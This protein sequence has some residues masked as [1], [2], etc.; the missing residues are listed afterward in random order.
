[1]TAGVAASAYAGIPVTHRGLASAVAFVTGH[2]REDSDEGIDWSGLARF[3]GTLVFYMGVRELDTIAAALIEAGRPFDQPAA[4]VEA[5]TLATQRT[6]RA[7]LAEIAQAARE[8]DVKS[9]AIA[10]VGEVAEMADMLAWLPERPLTGVRVVVTRAR[11][12]AS[13]LSRVL[14]EEGARVIEAPVIRTRAIDG[15]ALDPS[16][17]D[18]IAL[19]SPNAVAGLFA[20]LAAGGRDAR[21]LAGIRIAAIGPG[22]S[23]AAAARGVMADI[24]PA[25]STA[26]GLVEALEDVEVR[27]ALIPRALVAREVLPDALRARGAEVEIL[28]VYETLPEPLSERAVREALNADYVTFTSSSTVR[29][30]LAAAGAGF[31]AHTR[32]ISIGP[33]TTATLRE[34][35]LDPHVEAARHDVD[36]VVQAL[37]DDARTRI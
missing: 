24:A 20:R 37:L 9:P 31:S 18:L 1:V 25:T 11:D 23:E 21:A 28:P 16:G 8:Q 29:N 6:V 32:L 33:A 3:P 4:V 27:R 34:H 2:T 17:Y 12:R 19:T 35:G 14:R 15:P 22:T 10:V 26:E 5:G 30:F 36:G 13:G 7:P